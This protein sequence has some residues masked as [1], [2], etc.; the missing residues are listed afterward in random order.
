MKSV[1]LVFFLAA[2]LSIYAQDKFVLSGYV[3]DAKS[4]EKLIGVT[5]YKSGSNVGVNTN[6]YGYYSLSLPKG[7]HN[8]VFSYIGYKKVEKEINLEKKHKIRCRTL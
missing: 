8:I 2:S 4:G 5:V 6:E 1:F 3:K 7:N